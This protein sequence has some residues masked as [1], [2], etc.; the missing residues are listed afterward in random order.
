MSVDYLDPHVSGATIREHYVNHFFKKA[1]LQ[2]LKEW[3]REIEDDWN[4]LM[5][6]FEYWS[7]YK[8]SDQAEQIAGER[9]LWPGEDWNMLAKRVATT[10]VSALSLYYNPKSKKAE[11][12]KKAAKL[13]WRLFYKM[14]A[15][16]VALPNT[17]TLVN[18]GSLTGDV[19]SKIVY[20][21]IDKLDDPFPVLKEVFEHLDPRLQFAACNVLS[22][23]DS[24]DG[25]MRT[26]YR[27]AIISKAGGG[28]GLNFGKLRYK[29]AP[30]SHGGTS[31]GSL[32]FLEMF[33][34]MLATIKQ[35]GKTRRGAGMATHGYG[36]LTLPNFWERE[37]TIHPDAIDF[38]TSKRDNDGE[39]KLS[40][41]NIS[42]V[43][44]NTED[45][46]K[47]LEND[48]YVNMEFNGK[49]VKEKAIKARQL[50]KMLAEH[51]WKTGDPG[52]VFLDK[53]NK[54][55]PVASRI[56]IESVNVCGE[57]PLIS[58]YEY[59][60][61][62]N[63][64]LLSIDL[65]KVYHYASKHETSVV[66]LLT[67]LAGVAYEFLDFQLDLLAFP[68]EG[69]ARSAML[70]RNVGI[71]FTAL[72][73]ATAL[74]FIETGTELSMPELMA[75]LAFDVMYVLES[76]ARQRDKL[77]SAVFGNMA[78]PGLP[79][80][81]I[82]LTTIQPSGTV[83]IL[84]QTDIFGDV[85]QGIEP[86]Y[87]L[88]YIR[89]YRESNTQRWKTLEYS[90]KLLQIYYPE[91]SKPEFLEQLKNNHGSSKV[92][93]DPRIREAFT[94]AHEMHWKDHLKVLSAASEYVSSAVSKTIN[95]PNSA[96][97]KD[98]EEIFVEAMKDP[99]IKDV[100]I[101]R[102]GSLQTQ[103]LSAKAQA[104]KEET[105]TKTFVVGKLNISVDT[106]TGHIVPKQ[107]PAFINSIKKEVRFTL[108]G[109]QKTKKMYVE[110]GF[111]ENNEPFEVFFR[112]TESTKEFAPFMNLAGRMV[113]LALRSGV[114][115]QQIFKQLRKVK[116]W[117]NEYDPLA[118]IMADA[119]MEIIDF[120]RAKGKK[121]QALKDLEEMK[122]NWTLT[123]KGYYIDEEGNPR[124]PVCGEILVIESGCAS[125]KA[126]GYSACTDA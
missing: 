26:L 66:Q 11:L 119:V 28:I 108:N 42:F 45:F 68:D 121:K 65:F 62:G 35:G 52:L 23:E 82:A 60:L 58:S 59:N 14:I 44:N 104:K 95:L 122:R 36:N 56:P 64:N 73:G 8:P 87:S 120:V 84:M 126:C 32:S 20:T 24:L 92:I 91:A 125:C 97:I 114:D 113:S 63:C 115:K 51:A 100:T 31:S 85:G 5:A 99:N 101:Y 48:E 111:D 47:K 71:G 22:L 77:K 89:K 46:L 37:F 102:D 6:Y 4:V 57:Q 88:Y 69:Q 90:N 7:A 67:H 93:K 17:P 117:R 13:L 72:A 83:G 96:T 86:F 106:K 25:I 98:V 3:V 78:Y 27:A 112:A 105:K 50:L 9:Y 54:D 70:F 109:D 75:K 53:I 43:I 16:R 30:L 76:E 33:D 103:V 107:R 10:V 81:N 34:K 41:F 21:E 15:S 124:C 55:N 1:T 80:R 12:L 123:P 61:V 19:D 118:S 94:T 39:S 116:N 38:I 2:D 18:A 40:N 74:Q 49:I 110:V 29:D 79:Y